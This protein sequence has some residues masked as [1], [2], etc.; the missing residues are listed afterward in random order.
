MNIMNNI[1]WF[2]KTNV[3][4]LI[5]DKIKIKIHVDNFLPAGRQVLTVVT[6]TLPRQFSF[7]KKLAGQGR[8]W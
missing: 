4:T 3:Y 5:L 2:L 7:L 1:R 6:V 8:Q